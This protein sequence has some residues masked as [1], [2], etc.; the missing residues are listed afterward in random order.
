[1]SFRPEGEQIEI[2]ART[3][4]GEGQLTAEISQNGKPLG[5]FARAQSIPVRGD[6]VWVPLRWNG[7]A[8]LSELRGKKVQLHVLL[9]RAKVFGYRV[10][11]TANANPR[12]AK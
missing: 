6:N 2:N 8:D 4:A 9:N 11:A 5:G 7:K 3:T 10:V 1:M 12:T